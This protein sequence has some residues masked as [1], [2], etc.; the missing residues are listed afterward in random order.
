MTRVVVSG[1]SGNIGS[2]LLPLLRAAGLRPVA[3][4][5]RPPREPDGV[6]W[7][8][9]DLSTPDG[10]RALA[11]AL[12]GADAYVHLAWPLQPMRRPGLLRDRGPRML[13]PCVLAALEAGVDRVVHLSSVAAYA[14]G[15]GPVDE[16]WPLGGVADSPYAQDKALGER[17]LEHMLQAGGVGDRVAVLRPCLVGQRR[18]GGQMA[19]YGMP[20]P[21]AGARVVGHVPWVPVVRDLALQMVHADDVARAVLAVIERRASGAFNLAGDGVV[22]GSDVADALGARPVPVPPGLPRL[23]V[24]TAWHLHLGPL[25]PTWVDMAAGAPHMV[26][27]RARR[28]LD[29][30]PEHRA[31]DVLHE[32]VEGMASGAG[33]AGAA[34]RPAGPWSELRDWLAHGTVAR[35]TR[36]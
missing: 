13:L 34:L 7:V 1:A 25:D 8:R 18:A 5:R 30:R 11:R 36:P 29:W 21:L 15:A 20:A 14:P 35:R 23:A 3:L 33:R 9:A 31:V 10:Q 17:R 16:S 27:E 6:E 2:A 4:A 12:R 24:A 26:T 28:V 32:V 22:T 19:R